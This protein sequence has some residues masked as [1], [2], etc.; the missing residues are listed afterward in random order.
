MVCVHKVPCIWLWLSIVTV[1][2]KP[3]QIWSFSFFLKNWA[4]PYLNLFKRQA[5]VSFTRE[6]FQKILTG[7]ILTGENRFYVQRWKIWGDHFRVCLRKE[8]LKWKLIN[9]N[10][11]PFFKP[12]ISY[13][14]CSGED[15]ASRGC[16]NHASC[17]LVVI[18]CGL[19]TRW[20]PCKRDSPTGTTAE[21]R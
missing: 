2:W 11:H 3:V 14:L 10:K 18:K 8:H 7:V 19:F 16:L 17:W 6:R 12:S 5:Q 15:L 9:T 4:N 1:G 13:I 21:L 20:S